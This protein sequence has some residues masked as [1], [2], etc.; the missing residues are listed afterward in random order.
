LTLG[1]PGNMVNT[2]FRLAIGRGPSAS[3]TA[4]LYSSLADAA[5]RNPR[6]ATGDERICSYVSNHACGFLLDRVA[7]FGSTPGR[8]RARRRIAEGVLDQRVRT[9]RDSYPMRPEAIEE[10]VVIC[11]DNNV[12]QGEMLSA[13]AVIVAHSEQS[14]RLLKTRY[15]DSP[16]GNAKLK[17]AQILAVLGDPTGVPTLIAA[18]DAYDRWDEGVTLTSQRK[19]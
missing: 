17:Y 1:D 8:R 19:K 9:D 5:R 15:H 6:C 10:A 11:G 13:L 7:R 4:I 3:R 16:A 18:V 12:D 2:L 14:I